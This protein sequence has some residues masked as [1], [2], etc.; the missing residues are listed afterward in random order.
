MHDTTAYIYDIQNMYIKVIDKYPAELWQVSI[1]Q[2]TEKKTE[3]N[4]PEL[5]PKSVH[6]L[7]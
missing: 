3:K 5:L 1:Q 4:G 7:L 2:K 6:S